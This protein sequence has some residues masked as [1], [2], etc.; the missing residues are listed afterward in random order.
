MEKPPSAFRDVSRKLRQRSGAH[1]T[2]NKH[3]SCS[4][5]FRSMCS[6]RLQR[7]EREHSRVNTVP[8]L[9][10]AAGLATRN[11]GHQDTRNSNP[12]FPIPRRGD[13]SLPLSCLSSVLLSK[14][15]RLAR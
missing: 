6:M 12:S 8:I 10:V 15:N 4:P 1:T 7:S 13:N 5:V 11:R 9:Y 2:Q 3:P 14:S